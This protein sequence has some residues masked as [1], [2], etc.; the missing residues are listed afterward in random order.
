MKIV[1]SVALAFFLFGCSDDTTAT[2][3]KEKIVKHVNEAS[4]KVQEQVEK[5]VDEV[6]EKAQEVKEKT[7]DEIKE[8]VIEV[9]ETTVEVVEDAQREV[10][11][12]T[13]KA[14]EELVAKTKVDGKKLF[15]TS[16][17]SCH[18]LHAEKKALRKSQVIQ[19]WESS[20]VLAALQGYKDKTYGNSM[21]TI[22]EGKVKDLSAEDMKALSDYISSL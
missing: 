12:N 10:K 16:C 18:G 2:K 19:G 15:Q 3:A 9:K 4:Q 1:L 13:A 21:K 22:M 6:K 5:T 20:K 8:T 14:E 7:V 17:V 11:V